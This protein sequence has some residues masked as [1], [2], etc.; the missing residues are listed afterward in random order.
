MG[1]EKKV[2]ALTLNKEVEKITIFTFNLLSITF[3]FLCLK[4][5]HLN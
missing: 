2:S 1:K 5:A 3:L 4:L